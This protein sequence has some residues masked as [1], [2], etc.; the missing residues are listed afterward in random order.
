MCYRTGHFYLLLTGAP[1][2]NSGSGKAMHTALASHQSV[3]AR[4]RGG[5]VSAVGADVE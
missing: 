3:C 4:W 5:A 1:G 2:F